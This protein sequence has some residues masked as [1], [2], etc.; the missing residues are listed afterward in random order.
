VVIARS[1]K[2]RSELSIGS[3]FS[4]VHKLR[5]LCFA[6]IQSGQFGTVRTKS[7]FKKMLLAFGRII[8]LVR[9]PVASQI[10]DF[11]TSF[12]V[13]GARVNIA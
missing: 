9:L 10:S 6:D 3:L 5:D 2:D 4:E 11:S 13:R 1:G 7:F 12:Y 8:T